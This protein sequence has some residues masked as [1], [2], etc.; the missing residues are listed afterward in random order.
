[1]LTRTCHSHKNH[2]HA[3]LFVVGLPLQVDPCNQLLLQQHLTC[4]ALELPLVMAEDSA[5]FGEGPLCSAVSDLM[6]A[7][8]LGRHPRTTG[9]SSLHY[10]GPSDNP[11]AGISLRTIDPDRFVIKNEADNTVLEDI[12]ANMAFYEVYDG[13]VYMFQVGSAIG[14]HGYTI[15]I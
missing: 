2:I 10:V 9:L 12:E 1:M 11:A 8:L 3:S 7:G 4:A 6:A 15:R 13:A 14:G 5:L